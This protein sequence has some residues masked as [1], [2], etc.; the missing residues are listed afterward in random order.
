MFDE[1]LLPMMTAFQ[2]IAAFTTLM[3]PILSYLLLL[4]GWGLSAA[5]AQQLSVTIVLMVLNMRLQLK[6]LG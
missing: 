3:G 6:T 1:T 4:A 2:Q 5:Y